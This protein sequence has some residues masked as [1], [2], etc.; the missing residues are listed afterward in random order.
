M[1][2]HLTARRVSIGALLITV[3]AAALS[4]CIGDDD[5]TSDPGE[6]P[7]VYQVS[8]QALQRVQAA[9]SLV[10][11]MDGTYQ[12]RG[13][14]RAY[15]LVYQLLSNGV[16]VRW[17]I[18]PG[19]AQN[20]IDFAA[21]ARD[22]ESGA[23][24]GRVSYRGGPFIIAAED[25]AAAL[26]LVTAWL[27]G[28][29][30][31]VVHE[32]TAPFSAE[33]SLV[34]SSAPRLAVA[35]DRFQP[36]AFAHLNAAGIPDSTGGRWS[37]ASPD[38]L[39]E[40][41]LI[42]PSAAISGDGALLEPDGTPRYEHLTFTYYWQNA[43]TGDV[44]RE[45]R[46]WLTAS[47]A[48]H[49]FAQAESLRAIESNAS[50]RLLTTG[51]VVDDGPAACSVATWRP[52][53]PL[54][55]FDG[56]FRSTWDVMDSIGLAPGSAW[57]EGTARLL[58]NSRGSNGSSKVILMSGP[59]DGFAGN[60]RATYLAGFDYGFLL[61]VNRNPW[62]NNVRLF[63]NS[64]LASEANWQAYQ[65]VVHLTQAQ[66][67][68]INGNELT[69]FVAWDNQGSATA[70]S[71]ELQLAIPAGT[72]LM[73]SS[74]GGALGNGVVTWNLGNLAPAT[75]GEA[76]ITVRASGAGTYT[77][78]AELRYRSGRTPRSIFSSQ[79]VEL[80]SDEPPET[81]LLSTPST[82]TEETGAEL[83][84]SSSDA[85][86]TFE[87]SLDGAAFAAC[88]S[89][90]ALAGLA[91]GP[92]VFAV[93]AV[94]AGGQADATPA[95]Y[96][97]EIVPP[98]L[99][100]VANDDEA[101]LAEDG[102]ALIAVRGNDSGG[103]DPVVLAEISAP[104]HGSAAIVGDDVRYIPAADYHGADSFT[105]TLRDRN[106]DTATATVSLTV[107]PV[108]DT[109]TAN[110]DM[111]TILEDSGTQV[112]AVLAN[113]TGLGDGP[114]TFPIFTAPPNGTLEIVD[115]QVRYTPVANFSGTDVFTYTIRD[116]D[117]QQSNTAVFVTV[118]PVNDAPLAR[119]DTFSVLA[120]QRSELD[121][122][123]NDGDPDGNG[124]TLISVTQPLFGS[125]EISAGKIWFTAPPAIFG[126]ATFTY[127]VSDGQGGSATGTVT[128]DVL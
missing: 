63:L 23:S 107:T 77:A 46:A 62:T 91:I 113:D 114:I 123:Q 82:P 115:G 34:L 90:L 3:L 38:L 32:V 100:P 97:W 78:A 81:A 84:F 1:R 73:S 17:S 110:V 43:R 64:V 45:L 104:Q 47:P 27:A 55:Q 33:E 109:P 88:S 21:E 39:D 24:R 93:R 102:E 44:V 54:V 80:G 5:L 58:G 4:G 14:L 126:L 92:H 103:D 98:N 29:A 85:A 75:S 18:A 25:R 51:G 94:D 26:P 53:E 28:D 65:P 112:L 101:T 111:F 124:I 72:T 59:V 15:G 49:L 8:E 20:G 35:L 10:I 108:N 128:L 118:T 56:T 71:G 120:G 105:Y 83:T 74:A 41:E 67:V 116:V 68:A 22:L 96:S 9:G 117:G 7:G 76:S 66:P 127:G 119:D 31:T 79:S 60:G 52:S 125:V 13:I 42:G 99:T 40:S 86:A 11:P 12:A 70:R 2:H 16:P 122:L 36:I 50:G 48:T 6:A 57:R 106:G 30:V 61:P 69:F 89:P 37:S 87:C 121:V 95:A 19:K